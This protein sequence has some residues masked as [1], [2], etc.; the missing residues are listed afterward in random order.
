MLILTI[1]HLHITL[2][3]FL[4][5]YLLLLLLFIIHLILVLVT[6]S[7]LSFVCGFEKVNLLA[8]EHRVKVN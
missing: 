2:D 6:W 3:Q 4:F 5:I 8:C 1:A 7:F